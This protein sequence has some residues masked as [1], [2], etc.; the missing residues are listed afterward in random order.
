MKE[1]C[2]QENDSDQRLDRFLQK[3]LPRLPKSLFYKWIRTKHIK[4]NRKRC[5]PDQRLCVSDT[6]QLFVSDTYFEAEHPS[7]RTEAP[8]F[9]QAPDKLDILF[10]NDQILLVCKPVGLVVHCDNRQVPDT[11]IN[12]VLHYLYRTGAYDP[13]QEQSFTPALCNR[14][15][16]NTGGIVIAAKTAA[17]LREVNRL[18]REDRIHKTYLCV[19]VG[20]PKLHDAKLRA[21][22][23][24]SESH[25][26]VTVRDT[27]A[28]GFQEIITA[29]HVIAS[30]THH[31]LLSVDL[32]TGRTHQIRAHLAHIGT[33]ILG[34]T[35]Y[36]NMKENRSTHCKYQRLWAY[37]LTFSTDVGTCLADLDGLTVRT[38]LPA[39]VKQEFPQAVLS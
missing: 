37:Q 36:G 15:D 13:K 27:K 14:L 26:T 18:I 7:A 35:K 16:R 21:W 17:A 24:K 39:F 6:V 4:V 38:E 3:I 32:I 19:T 30:N 29:Y 2:I 22:H 28:D 9:L 33:P 20:T 12:R 31:A 8:E 11:L 10:E 23:K 1:F 5:T 34:D 25:N